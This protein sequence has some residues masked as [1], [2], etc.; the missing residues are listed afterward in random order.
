MHTAKALRCVL[1]CLSDVL[2]RLQFTGIVA[3]VRNDWQG[4]DTV[5]AYNDLVGAV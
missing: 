2:K 4:N 5:E 1:L 3:L